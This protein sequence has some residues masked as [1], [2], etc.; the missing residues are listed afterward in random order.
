MTAKEVAALRKQ[1]GLTQQQLAQKIG[2]SRESVSRWETG[3]HPPEVANLKALRYLAE[4]AKRRA[5]KAQSK[6]ASTYKAK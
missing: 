1:L 6:N 2:A 4:R 3:A 5:K